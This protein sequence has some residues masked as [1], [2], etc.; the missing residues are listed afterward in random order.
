VGLYQYISQWGNS[1][2]SYG[3]SLYTYDGISPLVNQHAVD[4]DYHW[5]TTKKLEA[6]LDLGFFKDK[7]FV[8]AAYYQNRTN[9]QLLSYP[10]P[11]FT[12]FSSVTANWP[13]NVQNNGWE[14]T[15]NAQLIHTATFSWSVNGNLSINRNMLLAYPGLASSPY[16]TMYKVGQSLNNVYLLHNTGVDPL[17]GQYSFQDY[18]HTGTTFIDPNVSPGTVDDDRRVAINMSPAYFGGLS[19]QFHYKDFGLSFFLHFKKQMAQNAYFGSGIPGQMGNISSDIFNSHWQQPGDK[20][21]FAKLTTQY[22]ASNT[23]IPFSDRAYTDASFIRLSNLYLTYSLPAAKAR[24]AGMQGCNLFIKTENL[25]VLTRYK[26]IDPETQN[27]GGMP[28]ARIF[29]GGLSFNF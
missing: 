28:P 6:A 5:A 4:Q 27:F 20:A 19:S 25:F 16:F 15:L 22:S 2:A 10:T 24:R 17:T 23:N 26:G 7:L 18:A 13:A 12:G 9:D 3:A 29:T 11:V 8:E 1:P 21:S 14:F